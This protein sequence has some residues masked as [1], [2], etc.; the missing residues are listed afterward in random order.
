MIGLHLIGIIYTLC[1]LNMMRKEIK[2]KHLTNKHFWRQKLH[3]TKCLTFWVTLIVTSPLMMLN[4][5]YPLYIASG[6][7]LLTIQILKT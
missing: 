6:V 2:L 5:L 3:C 4:V 7:T 1:I